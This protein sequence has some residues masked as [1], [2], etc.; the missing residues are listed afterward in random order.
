LSQGCQKLGMPLP[1]APG[2]YE[3]DD[4]T[5]DGSKFVLVKHVEVKA[6][7]SRRI[8]ASFAYF[9]FKLFFTHFARGL[10]SSLNRKPAWFGC[11]PSWGPRR[12]KQKV[13]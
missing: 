5:L 8:R 2:R 3:V 1:I 13:F 10:F 4:Q 11:N 6:M 7:E 12:Q 9:C